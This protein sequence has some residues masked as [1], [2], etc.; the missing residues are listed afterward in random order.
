MLFEKTVCVKRL[1]IDDLKKLPLQDFHWPFL[2][3]HSGYTPVFIFI[4][5][6]RLILYFI[7]IMNEAPTQKSR[8]SEVLSSGSNKIFSNNLFKIQNFL[9]IILGFY[10]WAFSEPDGK[11]TEKK[12][13]RRYIDIMYVNKF[14]SMSN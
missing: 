13:F 1:L 5:G 2:T 8:Q 9:N 12:I 14:V 10:S 11:Q 3:Q 7:R 6:L 4:Y